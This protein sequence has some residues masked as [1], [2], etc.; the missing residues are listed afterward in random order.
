MHY[1]T[2]LMELHYRTLSS[3]RPCVGMLK[4]TESY[5]PEIFGTENGRHKAFTTARHL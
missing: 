4:N 1:G 5:S 3:L 2:R